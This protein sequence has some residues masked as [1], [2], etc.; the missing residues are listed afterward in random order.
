VD[1]YLTNDSHT[2]D[3]HTA[4]CLA[5][6]SLVKVFMVWTP[7]AVKRLGNPMSS[8]HER[9]VRR[10]T[11]RAS[12]RYWHF[13]AA[14]T[15]AL[16]AQTAHSHTRAAPAAAL[17]TF[18]LTHGRVE[19]CTTASPTNYDLHTTCDRKSHTY[20]LLCDTGHRSCTAMHPTWPLAFTLRC[21]QY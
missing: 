18:S 11:P 8:D 4:I 13:T 2:F 19:R 5:L 15:A 16:L 1:S 14:H 12:Q 21:C 17:T 3:A 10:L 7:V 9:G 6:I 20:L